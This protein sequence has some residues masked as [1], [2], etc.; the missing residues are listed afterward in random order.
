LQQDQRAIGTMI[1]NQIH[2]I[3]SSER[4]KDKRP[5]VFAGEGGIQVFLLNA[6]GMTGQGKSISA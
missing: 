3:I 6:Y 4:V 1:E 5:K 2:Y